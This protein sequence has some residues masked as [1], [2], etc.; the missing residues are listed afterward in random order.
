MLLVGGTYAVGLWPFAKGGA[1][2]G[3]ALSLSRERSFLT[4]WMQK[5]RS[6]EQPGGGEATGANGERHDGS[7][8]GVAPTAKSGERVAD[9]KTAAK[10][11]WVVVASVT[12]TDADR[13]KKPPEL[14]ALFANEEKR[15]RKG[16]G[17]K[18]DGFEIQPIFTNARKEEMVLRLGRGTSQD[19]PRLIDLR[20]RVKSLGGSFKEATIRGYV[21]AAK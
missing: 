2:G 13:K 19:D 20:D 5:D 18:L 4:D 7:G 16:L 9:A 21:P 17:A 14:K 6:G 12:L 10:E 1:P 11:Y 3:G 8:D 15:L